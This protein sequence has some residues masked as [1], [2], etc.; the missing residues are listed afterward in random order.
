MPDFF[1]K[2]DGKL[3]SMSP[4]TSVSVLS[5]SVR[6][7]ELNLCDFTLTL[8][9]QVSYWQVSYLDT[10]TSMNRSYLVNTDFKF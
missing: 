8:W 1:Y 4:E 2:T 7:S 10:L 5:N 9:E 3:S 6:I